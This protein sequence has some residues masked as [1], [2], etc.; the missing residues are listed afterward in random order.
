MTRHVVTFNGVN[1]SGSTIV[2]KTVFPT[3]KAVEV[4]EEKIGQ[5]TLAR[6][7]RNPEFTVKAVAAPKP[8][9]KS[10]PKPPRAVKRRTSRKVK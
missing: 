8:K 5:V 9:A 1:E 2:A 7:Q 3:G 10:E 4:D 6:L